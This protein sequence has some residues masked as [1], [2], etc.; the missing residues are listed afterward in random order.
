M[1]IPEAELKQAVAEVVVEE[2]VVEEEI[3]QPTHEEEVEKASQR[4]RNRNENV[5]KLFDGLK[6]KFMKMFEDV[7]DQEIN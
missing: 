2:P 6:G 3:K 1:H 7:E 5:K 4:M